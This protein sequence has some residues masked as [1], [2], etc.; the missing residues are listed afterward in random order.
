[1]ILADVE[2]NRDDPPERLCAYRRLVRRRVFDVLRRTWR[3]SDGVRAARVPMN[4][5]SA[6]GR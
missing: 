3:S 4:P 5:A 2:L 1:M 6:A